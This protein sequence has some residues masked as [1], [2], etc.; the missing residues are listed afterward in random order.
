MNYPYRHLQIIMESLADILHVRT[1]YTVQ[2]LSEGFIFICEQ[3]IIFFA[4]MTDVIDL[5][6][7]TYSMK[8]SQCIQ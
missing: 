6:P 3:S 8:Y 5:D 2:L 4:Q 7:I 1:V